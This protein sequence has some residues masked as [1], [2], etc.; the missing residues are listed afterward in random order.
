MP[1]LL[2][3]VLLG[4]CGRSF[5]HINAGWLKQVDLVY[6]E[7]EGQR[8]KA[9]FERNSYTDPAFLKQLADAMN[10]SS[11]LSGELDYGV[12]FRM[13]LTYGDGYTEDYILNLGQASGNPG[14]LVAESKSSEGYSIPVKKADKLR[15]LVYS[16]AEAEAEQLAAVI[17]EGPVT[18]SRNEL[19]TWTGR[20]EYLNLQLWKGSYSEDWTTPSPLGGRQWRGQFKLTVTDDTGTSLSSYDFN[21]A[22]YE[23][24]SFD[25]P[26]PVQFGDYN[27][28]GYPD[29][30]IGQYASSNGYEYKLFTLRNNVVEELTVKQH[31]W[32][33]IS[34]GE[35]RYSVRLQNVS[36]GFAASHYDNSLGQTVREIFAWNGEEFAETG[37]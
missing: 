29:F 25:S 10:S 22:P 31:P 7:I 24:L 26:F 14:L 13:K 3:A 23:E 36:G 12:E 37:Q 35:G 21:G 6:E 27:S 32:L 1:I 30:T 34:G 5:G 28:D 33:F 8:D 20:R 16:D 17:A 9:P 11:R 4:G 15:A 2:L 19:Y 18:L